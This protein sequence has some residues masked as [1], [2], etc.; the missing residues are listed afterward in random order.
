[1][2]A[3]LRRG[4]IAAQVGT[5]LLLA[6]EAGTNAAHRAALKNPEFDATLVTRAFSGRYAR[7]LANNFTRLLDH[8]APLGYPEVHQMTKPIRAAAVQADDPHGTNLWAGSAH[9]KTRPGPAADIIASLTP[10]VCS[11]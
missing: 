8:V 11:A 10:D 2:A 6:D 9:R 3:V 5:A 7:G 4:A 1:M